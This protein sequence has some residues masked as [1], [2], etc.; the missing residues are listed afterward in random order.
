MTVY[1]VLVTTMVLVSTK[2]VD[3]NASARQALLDHVAKETS[4]SA[5]QIPVGA[6]VHKIVCSLSTTTCATASQVTWAG[7]VKLR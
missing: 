1:L 6:L 3:L 4:M 7:I 5:C 2:W